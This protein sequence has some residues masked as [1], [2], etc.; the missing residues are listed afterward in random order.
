MVVLRFVFT[1]IDGRLFGDDFRRQW[2]QLGHV[3]VKGWGFRIDHTTLIDIE[4]RSVHRR[5]HLTSKKGSLVYMYLKWEGKREKERES[6]KKKKKKVLAVCEKQIFSQTVTK[7]DLHSYHFWLT[8]K[9]VWH[10]T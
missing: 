10:A 4:V 2:C 8:Y 7:A 5:H 6:P 1:D 3:N 9:R